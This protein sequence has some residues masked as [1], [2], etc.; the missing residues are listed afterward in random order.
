MRSYSAPSIIAARLLALALVICGPPLRAQEASPSPS[1][2]PSPSA[3]APAPNAIPLPKVPSE[4]ESAFTDLHQIEE[5]ASKDRATLDSAA[6]GLSDLTTEIK[7][8]MLED[9]RILAGDP[10]LDLLFRLRTTLQTYTDDLS[11]AEQD[12]TQRVANLET[13]IGRLSQM[14]QVW[15]TTLKSAP[16]VD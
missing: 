3:A 2:S 11:K 1:S 12:L 15:E 10:S 13:Q 6:A 5:S 4:A 16:Q 8:R 9:N 14:T 7:N